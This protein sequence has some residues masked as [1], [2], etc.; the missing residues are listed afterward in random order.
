M[1]GTPTRPLR[2][3]DLGIITAG[4]STSAII[5]DLG[6][7]VIK[8]ESASYMDP[9]R[10]WDIARGKPRWWDDSALYK[11]T[12][13]NKRCVSIDL[14]L[15]AGQEAVL[16]LVR[17]ADVV[18]ENF[19]RGVM[20]KL[21]LGYD[22]L[23]AANPRIVLASVSSQGE[24]GP[25]RD[26]VSFGSTLDAT[27]GLAWLTG[28]R[29]GAPTISG[30][31]VNYPD[32][33][34][35]VFAAGM[36]LAAVRHARE[37]GE[38]GHLDLPQRELASFL[39]GEEILA[40]AH[41]GR[42]PAREGNASADIF[43]QDCVKARDGWVAVT[44]PAA[45]DAR[46]VAAAIDAG[47]VSSPD[48]IAKALAHWAGER[49]ADDAVLTLLAAGVPAA[50]VRDAQGFAAAPFE[51]FGWA[52]ARDPEGGIAKGFPFQRRGRPLAVRGCAPA[53][54]EHTR[55]VLA[56]VLGM[57]EA[58]IERLEREGVTAVSPD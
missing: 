54:G 10:Q 30:R 48:A 33:V 5:A 19:R 35:S 57:D 20:Q 52:L 37:T 24:D 55:D 41:A 36:I 13:R 21:G 51:E 26:A 31:D 23:R 28:Y 9:F 56:G 6:A 17:Q 1:K 4:A 11:F 46:R 15:K 3:V 16:D 12:N 49:S 29:G 8:V 40:A 22:A 45:E 53:L 50:R 47:L 42:D 34:V 25:E 39:I 18:V 44:L 38:G 2:V 43:W 27:S 14:K 7:D 32:Q 58:E